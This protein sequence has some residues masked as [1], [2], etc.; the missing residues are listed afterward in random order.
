MSELVVRKIQRLSGSVRPPSDKSLTHRAYMLA[1][2]AEGQSVI[3]NPLLGEDCESTLACLRSCGAV[4]E[5]VDSEMVRLTGMGRLTGSGLNLDCG[6]SGT[7]MRLLSGLL[8]ASPGLTATL[9][10]DES[11]SRRPMSRIVEPLQ[12][13]GADIAGMQAP[14]QITGKELTPI[15]YLSPVASAQVKSCVLLAGTQTAGETS[16]TEPALS[17]DH[18]E[19]M[20]AHLGVPLKFE[21]LKV[22]VSQAN[23][24]PFEFR[25]PGDISSAAFWLVG[26]ALTPH[27][28]LVLKDVG[29][30]PTRT[31]ILDVLESAGISVERENERT[32][33][34][35]S[36]A[37]LRVK[38]ADSLR[39]FEISGDLVPRLIDEIPVLAVLAT[40][41]EGT[42]V[43]RDASELRVK[44]T[45][46]I[47]VVADALSRMGAEVETTK[48]GMV[49]QGPT[50]LVGTTVDSAG[51]HRIGM[52]FT[53]AG[54]IAE[55]ETRI[56]N[57]EA[58]STSYP[59]FQEHF[60]QLAVF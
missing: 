21:G 15:D 26:A 4:T 55:G 47:A 23:W 29:V 14:L 37:D 52:A 18:T 49:I 3:H 36:V 11:L 2:M 6:N 28:D 12:L 32:E 56:V 5:V 38:G 10:G 44:E 57:A 16:V 54:A 7:T 13:M 35:E 48:D 31:G 42:T 9:T 24:E 50:K 59:Q 25:V 20:L 45:D 46:R 22:T 17:R 27:S 39:A 40:Q 58:I 8:A 34:G 53:I 19:L 33:L 41:C 1:A 30:N 51:D 60:E 43:I